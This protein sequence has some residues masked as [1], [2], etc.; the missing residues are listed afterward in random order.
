MWLVGWLL[1]VSLTLHPTHTCS[2]SRVQI[3]HCALLHA[4]KWQQSRCM[5]QS[6]GRQSVFISAVTLCPLL[7]PPN[8]PCPL[9]Y[10]SVAVRV[11]SRVQCL[12]FHSHVSI[13]IPSSLL[14]SWTCL[15]SSWLLFPSPSSRPVPPTPS[16]S[17]KDHL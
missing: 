4:V 17:A 2:S 1:T 14:H 15:P 3:L 5:G 7:T 13:P 12:Y 8:A 11:Y 9:S 10:T 16:G 6:V